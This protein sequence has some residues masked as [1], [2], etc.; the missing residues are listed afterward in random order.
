[1]RKSQVQIFVQCE[2]CLLIVQK[3]QAYGLDIVHARVY[4][5]THLCVSLRVCEVPRFPGSWSNEAQAEPE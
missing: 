2:Q 4:V 5:H 1:V 3:F